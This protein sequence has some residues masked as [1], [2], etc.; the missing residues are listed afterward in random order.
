MTTFTRPTSLVPEEDRLYF[1]DILDHLD[2]VMDPIETTRDYLS[3]TVEIYTTRATQ[4]IQKLTA[5]STVI[6]PLMFITSI[7]GMNF[8]NMPELATHH[9]YFVVLGA[10]SAVMLYYLHRRRML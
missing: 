6:L 4:R 9:G 2:Q 5:I 7:H 1:Q 8:E 10:L 3:S